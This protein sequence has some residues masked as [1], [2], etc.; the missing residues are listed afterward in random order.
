MNRLGSCTRVVFLKLPFREI[1]VPFCNEVSLSGKTLCCAS[2]CFLLMFMWWLYF[3]LTR[4]VFGQTI[5]DRVLEISTVELDEE[6][7]AD[8]KAV[9]ED[10]GIKD[11]FEHYGTFHL[12]DSAE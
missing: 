9:F 8:I 5:A 3:V 1:Y 10:Q 12:L 4:F 6:I 11:A 7:G 2:R